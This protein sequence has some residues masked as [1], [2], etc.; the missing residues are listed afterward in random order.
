MSQQVELQTNS[1]DV[2]ASLAG[3]TLAPVF[4]YHKYYKFAAVVAG[5]VGT[6]GGDCTSG[7]IDFFTGYFNEL[8]DTVLKSIS[9][10]LLENVS[11][12][13]SAA[14]TL[15]DFAGKFSSPCHNL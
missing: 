2:I 14:D 6:F 9:D 7:L 3:D 4:G 1:A 10:A 13:T 15:S 12:Y 8:S 11:A 5:C